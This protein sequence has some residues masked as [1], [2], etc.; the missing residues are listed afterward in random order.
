L[1]YVAGILPNTTV[2]EKGEEPLPPK[3][4]SGRATGETDAPRCQASADLGQGSRAQ[5]ACKRL[6]QSHLARRRPERHVP[7]SIAT[8]RR[9]LIAKLVTVLSRCPCC[10][11]KTKE[12]SR[13][14]L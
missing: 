14:N 6:A 3:K 11:A 13:R 8:L 4:A 7:N 10:G 5:Y 9:R 12:R 2:W 1:T